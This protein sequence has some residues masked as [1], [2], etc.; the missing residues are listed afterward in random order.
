MKNVNAT[1]MMF[2]QADDKAGPWRL[3]NGYN[4][5]SSF[6]NVNSTATTLFTMHSHLVMTMQ[7]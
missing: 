6:L 2:D 4:V 1:K 5:F 3:V 7:T